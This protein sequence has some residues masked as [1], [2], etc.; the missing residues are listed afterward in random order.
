MVPGTL[1]QSMESGTVS[2]RLTERDSER[3]VRVLFVVPKSSSNHSMIFVRRQVC[4]LERAGVSCETF[5]LRSRTSLR[6]LARSWRRLRQ[7][8]HRFRPDLLHA[9]Y[10]TMTGFLS[11]AATTIPLV[12]TFRG[13]DLIPSPD[14]HWT[15]SV[16]SRML[17]QAAALRARQ[18]I[19]VSEQLRDRLWIGRR[20]ASVIPTGVDTS[21]FYP[22]P[23]ADARTQ[24]GWD[25][26]QRIVLFNA[27]G[28]PKL[29]RLD[30][31][32]DAVA[33]ASAICGHTRLVVLHGGTDPDMVPTMMCAS[34]CLLVAS[35]SEG[36]PNVVKE[37]M[38]C[39][40][41]VVSVDVGD[42]RERL[43]D[44][45]PSCITQRRPEDIGRALASI[46][47]E[48]HRSNGRERIC[49]L[50]IALVAER[51][52]SVYR[53]ALNRDIPLDC[54]TG[55]ERGPIGRACHEGD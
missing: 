5:F 36:S 8:I 13:S 11:A 15:R 35:E 27:G 4:S 16:A 9:Q 40:L 50:S 26:Q 52:L 6:S 48:G 45:H 41:P 14:V 1:A 51:I 33:Y 37:A 53:S 23:R 21:S 28:D 34:D 19:C 29:K 47:T 18:I 55:R 10:G 2:D 7:A 39:N 25:P 30:L 46:L 38:A 22:Q 3:P 32:Y 20:A 44:V 54:R 31:A 24:L 12:V 49:H 43:Q 42:V 17:S